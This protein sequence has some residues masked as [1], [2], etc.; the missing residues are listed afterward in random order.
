MD[1]CVSKHFIK[2]GLDLVMLDKTAYVSYGINL[3]VKFVNKVLTLLETSYHSIT[4]HNNSAYN[5][6]TF[7]S[8]I[9]IGLGAV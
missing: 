9:G 2:T 3:G 6:F 7:G 5:Y 4:V 8:K 1:R